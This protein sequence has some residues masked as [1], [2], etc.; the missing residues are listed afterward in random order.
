MD[1]SALRE[2]R[3]GNVMSVSELNQYI[4]RVFDNDRVLGAVSVSGEISNFVNHRS[5]HLYFS[6]KDSEGQV[7]AIMFR[8]SAA[9]LKFIPE[10]GMK[11]T[12]RGSVT[13]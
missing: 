11:V 2:P 13:G 6:L 1:I 10:N 4:K 8:S 9:R 12:V 5:G 7:R 3:G